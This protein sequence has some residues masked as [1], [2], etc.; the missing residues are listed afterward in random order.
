MGSWWSLAT[1]D[2]SEDEEFVKFMKKVKKLK[3]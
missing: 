3:T 2:Y 1:G